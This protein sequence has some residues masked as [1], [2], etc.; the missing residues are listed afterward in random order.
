MREMEPV[1]AAA[2]MAAKLD[3][4]VEDPSPLRSTNNV[5]VWLRPTPVV[6][7]IAVT[8]HNQLGFELR[9][10]AALDAAGAPVVSPSS[11]VPPVVHQLDG[12]DMT[13]WT[14]HH[15][16]GDT[17]WPEEVADALHRNGV[18]WPKGMGFV[19]S[20]PIAGIPAAYAP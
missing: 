14:Y 8:G 4:A 9:V 15:Q 5:V 1:A 2:T 16:S 19:P 17:A 6:A 10:A 11:L 3:L 20:R 18:P 7:K 13:F 12:R